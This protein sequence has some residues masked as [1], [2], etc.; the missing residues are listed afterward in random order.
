MSSFGKM[1]IIGDIDADPATF[2]D[3]LGDTLAQVIAQT[4]DEIPPVG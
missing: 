2:K 4:C 3:V 1:P